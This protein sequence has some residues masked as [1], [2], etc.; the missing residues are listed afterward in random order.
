[1]T[2]SSRVWGSREGFLEEV[3]IAIQP[4]NL[5]LNRSLSCPVPGLVLDSR[6]W[7]GIGHRSCP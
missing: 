1:M 7:R 2:N 3:T 5:P 6:D 4:P